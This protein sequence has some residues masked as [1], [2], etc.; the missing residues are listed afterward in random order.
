M[1]V[2]KLQVTGASGLPARSVIPLRRVTVYRVLARNVPVGLSVATFV[3]LEYVTVE[4]KVAPF[5]ARLIMKFPLAAAVI[6]RPV[7]ASLKVAVMFAVRLIPV[8]LATG[9]RAVTT[10]AGPVVKVH[11]FAVIGLPARSW[12]A[13]V[14]DSV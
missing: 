2:V 3:V 9:V 13:L 6:G 10:G 11:V 14:R 12:T 7:T 1:P 5:D 8:A 4:L